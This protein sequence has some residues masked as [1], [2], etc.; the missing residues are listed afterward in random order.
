MRLNLEA[1][2][3]TAAQAVVDAAQKLGSRLGG[4]ELRGKSRPE[5]SLTNADVEKYLRKGGRDFVTPD[6]ACEAKIGEII[7]T[8]F[9]KELKRV[10]ARNIKKKKPKKLT[11]G[12]AS[13]V[14]GIALKKAMEYWM[15]WSTTNIE[16]KRLADGGIPKRVTEAYARYRLKKYGVPEDIVGKATGELLENLVDTD[17]INLIRKK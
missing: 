6:A 17:S 4:V 13:A 1:K 11:K 7:E 12:Q 3:M 8:I 15:E 2:G 9:G 5:G 16:N 14:C 10:Q